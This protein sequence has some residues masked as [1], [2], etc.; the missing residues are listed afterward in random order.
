MISHPERLPERDTAILAM[1]PHVAFDGWS[2][3]ALRAGIA[4]AAMPADEADLLFP[5]GTVD[6]IETFC[7]LADRRME[8]AAVTLLETKPSA[9]IRAI[10]ALRLAQNRPYKE[11]IRRALSVLALP[12]NAGA[13][14]TCT[15]RTVDAI[16]HAAGDRSAD[17]SWYTKR[18]TLS[19][20]YSATLLYWLR[21]ASEDDA[22]TLGF[23]DRQVAVLARVRRLRARA[24]NLL[25]RLPRL[26]PPRAVGDTG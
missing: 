8:E 3:R 7:D 12:Q 4:D 17:F 11:A 25:A 14:A 1:L 2:R 16:W 20:I 5:L 10:V 15:A 23:L 6:M 13:A 26:R 24:D 19:G 18:A 9:R 22:P 21:D